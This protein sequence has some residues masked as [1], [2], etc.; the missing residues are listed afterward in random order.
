MQ[1]NSFKQFNQVLGQVG[2]YKGFN[3]DRYF[4]YIFSLW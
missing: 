1:H 3:G 4:I 2:I